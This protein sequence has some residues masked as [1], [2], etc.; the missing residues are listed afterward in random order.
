MFDIGFA[1]LVL[2]AIVALLVIGPERLPRVARTAGLWVGKMRGFVSSVQS[3]INQELKADELKKIMAEQAESTGVHEILED[4]R[5]AKESIAEDIREA[6]EEVQKPDYVLNAI[7][8][9]KPA[10]WDGND[11]GSDSASN[12]PA[13]IEKQEDS[14]K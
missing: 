13:Q 9:E 8:D 3:D 14:A 1:E 6:G 11:D 2:I 10:D 4:V 12:E 7:P 5:E